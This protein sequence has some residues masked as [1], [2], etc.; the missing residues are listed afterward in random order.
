MKAWVSH[1]PGSPE[2]LVLQDLPDP[3][4]QAGELT[5]R[6]QAIGVNYPDG[7]LIRDLYQVRPQRPFVPGSEFCGEVE[8][9][10]AAVTRFRPGDVVIGRCGWGAM[11]ERIAIGEGRCMRV[12]ASTPRAEAAAFLFTYA[13]AYH[14]L[15]DAGQLRPGQTVLVLG[16]AGGVG[17]AA[18][19]VGRALG[20]R[21][22]VAVSSRAKLDFALSRGAAAGLIYD[23]ELPDA[24]AQQ[25][26]AKRFKALVGDDGSDIVLDP[27]GGNYSEPALRCLAR[28]G[29]HLVVGFTAGIPRVPL[30]LAL[31]KGRQII[32][33]D[34]R[35]FV[36]HDAALNDRNVHSLLAMWQEGLIRPEVTESFPLEQAPSAIAR[37]ESRC[38][39][40]KIVVTVGAAMH[41]PLAKA[42]TDN[43]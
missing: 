19:E 20:A 30:N 4:P 10:G 43:H 42:A 13:T 39:I 31:L 28:G 35:S 37:L 23:R 34:W 38:A 14:A 25:A 32:G 27:V 2:T 8:E 18:V 17:S 6:V 40:G 12:P 36:Q 21:V 5:V 33:V 29:R 22:V 11:A 41:R 24:A 9:V 26:L 7:L 1:S 3:T 15:R 16:A